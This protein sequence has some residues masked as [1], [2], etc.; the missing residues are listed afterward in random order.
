MIWWERWA[1][2]TFHVVVSV[3]GISYFYM[4]YAMSTDDPF[5]VVNHPWQSTM[6]SLHVIAAPFFIVFFGMLF[7]SHSLQ[8]ILSPIAVNRR[9][10]W[11][12]LISFSAMVL[13]GY[14]IQV[15][16]TPA[17]ITL[18]IWAHIATSTVFIVGYGVHLIIGRRVNRIPTEEPETILPGSVRLSL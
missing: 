1:F 9:T 11:T 18:V 15:A 10:G 12:S 4:K 8:K 5:A 16:T 3:T 6:L 17:L 2:N 13:S 14:F 7:R